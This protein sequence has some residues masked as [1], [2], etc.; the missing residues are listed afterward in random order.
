M[1][2]L[3]LVALPAAIAWVSLDSFFILTSIL[4]VLISAKSLRQL[5]IVNFGSEEA[6]AQLEQQNYQRFTPCEKTVKA[7][8]MMIFLLNLLF[9]IF[10]LYTFFVS[11]IVFLRIASGLAVTNWIYDMMR[12]FMR[13][14]D[15]D[16]SDEWT[17]KDT[18]SE[19]FLWFHNILTIVV[20]VAV[21]AVK[22]L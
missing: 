4:V 1:M 19:F 15:V 14:Q 22:F 6:F 17:F 2:F 16:E 11:D 3:Y 21:F 10:F 8:R 18:L 7:N 20:V 13:S 12:T 9:V 5:C